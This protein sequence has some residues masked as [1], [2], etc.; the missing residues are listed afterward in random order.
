MHFIVADGC[1]NHLWPSPLQQL[2]NRFLRSLLTR[3]CVLVSRCLSDPQPVLIIRRDHLLRRIRWRFASGHSR[4]PNI[5]PQFARCC[6]ASLGQNE[7]LS[8][9][10]RPRKTIPGAGSSVVQNS[11][12]TKH[13]STSTVHDAD[14]RRLVQGFGRTFHLPSSHETQAARDGIYIAFFWYACI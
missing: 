5:Y 2:T 3:V 12:R 9:F 1:C 13:P 6:R 8:S 11:V 10:S 4:L 7:A 14:L